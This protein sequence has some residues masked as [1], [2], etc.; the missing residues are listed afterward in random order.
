MKAYQTI[1]IGGGSGGLAFARRAALHGRTVAVF[2]DAELGGTCVNR[3]CVPKKVMWHAGALAHSIHDAAD[4][5]FAVA[6]GTHDWARLKRARDAYVER[7][8]GIYAHN[9]E[10]DG[11]AW[12]RDRA[13]L[14]GPDTV[15]AGGREYRAE[16]VVI[17]TG[18]SPAV[19]DVPGAA[20]GIDSDGFFELDRRPVKV[21]VVG[22]GYVAVELSGVL[23]ALG[24]GVTVFMRGDRPLRN[25]D[26]LL[27][28]TLHECMREDGIDVRIG[29]SVVALGGK[30]GAITVRAEDGTEEGPFDTVIWATGRNPRTGGLGLDAAGVAADDTGAVAT[31]LYQ[32]TNVETVFALG[33]V[34]GRVALTPVAIAAGRRLA[35]R[36]YGGQPDRHLDYE[37]VPTVI[38][39]HPPIGMVGLSEDAARER[40]GDAVR[41]HVARFT[42][43][44]YGVTER[45]VPARMKM[46]TVGE[47]ERIVGLHVIGDGADEML[48]GFAVA[49]RMG[50]TKRDFDDT[51]AIHPTSAEEFVTMK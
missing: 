28:E 8:N 19:P 47:D 51:V 17:A 46:V 11:V 23:A 34:T 44:Y 9:L 50:A 29:A 27:S 16:H 25:F 40:H 12:I 30:A 20:L 45:R 2:E 31:D 39:S 37:L 4:Y 43:L 32:R 26:S 36:L 5:G 41:V 13:A 33:D 35:D 24:S 48:Q 1:V 22:G 7:L 18:G 3:G 10:K 15:T 42:P 21:A 14:T 38:F 49:V 6:P